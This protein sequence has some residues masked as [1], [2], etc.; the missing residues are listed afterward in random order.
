MIK[1]FR[2]WLRKKYLPA[3]AVESYEE[4]NERLRE[5]LGIAEL[6]NRRLQEHIEGMK[7]ALRAS[8]AKIYWGG[9]RFGGNH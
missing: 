5:K 6:E 9:G 3:W 4:E 2:D 7:D 1:R 8:S